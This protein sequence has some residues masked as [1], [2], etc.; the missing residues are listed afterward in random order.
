MAERSSVFSIPN[1]LTALRLL[2]I[3]PLLISIHKG[4]LALEIVLAV[5]IVLTDLLDG[6]S[7]RRLGLESSFGEY[8]D[9]VV[10]FIGYYSL[11]IYFVVMGRVVLLNTLLVAVATVALVLIAVSLSRK[12]GRLFMPHRRSSKVM[13]GLLLLSLAALIFTPVAANLV[14]FSCLLVI[15]AYTISDYLIFSCNYRASDHKKDGNCN[16]NNIKTKKK[17]Q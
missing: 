1:Y 14:F 4:S 17:A 8:F 11:I 15:Y 16:N 10:D 12:A 7:A 9:F 13:A 2:L 5:A 6:W 3:A